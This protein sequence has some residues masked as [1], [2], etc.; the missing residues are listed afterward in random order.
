MKPWREIN[1]KLKEIGRREDGETFA[2]KPDRWYV[3]AHWRCVNDHVS[4]A[5]LKSEAEGGAVC[6]ECGEW[7]MLTFPEDKDG[8]L[9]DPKPTE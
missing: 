5:Y 2:G 6:L 7:V 4:L 8:P 9:V 3:D 1:E